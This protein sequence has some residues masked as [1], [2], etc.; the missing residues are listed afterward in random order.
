MSDH[1]WNVPKNLNIESLSDIPLS[2]KLKEVLI[3]RGL[4]NP[5]A[6]NNYLNPQLL[7]D[8]AEHFPDLKNSSRLDTARLPIAV[9]VPI[10][11]LPK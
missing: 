8:P 7:P 6:I 11:A 3:R 1:I 9:R 2:S 10:V 5:K 4:T